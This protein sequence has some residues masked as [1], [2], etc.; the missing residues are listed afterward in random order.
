MEACQRTEEVNAEGMGTKQADEAK[1][2]NMAGAEAMCISA[3]GGYNMQADEAENSLEK[4]CPTERH[5][6]AD[7]ELRG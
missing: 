5:T 7:Q 1:R 4:Y 3:E 2:T 6:V